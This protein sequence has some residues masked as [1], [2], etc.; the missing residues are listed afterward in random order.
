MSADERQVDGAHYKVPDSSQEHWNLVIAYK[1]DY[2]QAQ[3][4]KYVMRWEL[5]G[6][7]KDLE[8]AQ[9]FLEKYIEMV[10]QTGGEKEDTGFKW[11]GN[12]EFSC[13]KCGAMVL[14]VWT[15]A[16]ARHVHGD[17]AGRGYVKQD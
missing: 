6:G 5:K 7:I 17:C 2:F 15:I 9:H 3:I 14:G 1:W 16:Q 10:K 13:L 8:K 4:I 11:L 12:K